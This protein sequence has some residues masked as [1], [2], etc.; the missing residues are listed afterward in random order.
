MIEKYTTHYKGLTF[1]LL[2]FIK[3]RMLENHP[4]FATSCLKNSSSQRKQHISIPSSEENSK[5]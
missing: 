2:N 3:K 1:F 5:T 4:Y